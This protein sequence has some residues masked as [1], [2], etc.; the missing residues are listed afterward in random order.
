M[1][2]GTS[3]DIDLDDMSSAIKTLTANIERFENPEDFMDSKD[4]EDGRQEDYK[5]KVA[6]DLQ[7]QLSVVKMAIG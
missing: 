6:C 2:T 4:I 1:K 7:F 5:L 3:K